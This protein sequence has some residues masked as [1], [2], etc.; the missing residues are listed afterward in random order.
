MAFGACHGR[1]PATV[2]TA[3]CRSRWA[4]WQTRARRRRRAPVTSELSA[5]RRPIAHNARVAALIAAALAAL[6]VMATGHR[7][8]PVSVLVC[9]TATEKGG[10]RRTQK[11]TDNTLGSTQSSYSL[12]RNMASCPPGC[13]TRRSVL[14]LAAETRT[15]PTPPPAASGGCPLFAGQ[16]QKRRPQKN[17]EEH[18]KEEH[19]QHSW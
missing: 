9:R 19:R 7:V 12:R 18:R 16:P 8:D 14:W 2:A 15:S 11:S 6:S 4:W 1:V 13:R 10:H 3:C 5:W 17:A